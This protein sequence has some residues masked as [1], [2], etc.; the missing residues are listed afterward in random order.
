MTGP[1]GQPPVG[2]GHE[3]RTL[4]VAGQHVLDPGP[5]DR[6]D[7]PDVLLTGDAEDVCDALVLQALHDQFRRGAAGS[8]RGHAPNLLAAVLA[9][10]APS[11]RPPARGAQPEPDHHHTG[12]EGSPGRQHEHVGSGHAASTPAAGAAGMQTAW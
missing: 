4:L 6:V 7:Q 12:A 1:A 5:G 9:L 2:L 3:R 11:G 8:V 10:P